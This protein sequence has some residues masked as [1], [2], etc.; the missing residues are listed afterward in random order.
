MPVL[1]PEYADHE[2]R[3]FQ[4]VLMNAEARYNALKAALEEVDATRLAALHAFTAAL[5]RREQE[6]AEH[7]EVGSMDGDE[8]QEGGEEE[9][10]EE[11]GWE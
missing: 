11:E 7:A 5:L 9:E 1:Y 6:R 8:A 3:G 10:E 2:L 4:Q